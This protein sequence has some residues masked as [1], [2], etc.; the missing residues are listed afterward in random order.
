MVGAKYLCAEVGMD[1]SVYVNFKATFLRKRSFICIRFSSSI[2][3]VVLLFY[4]ITTLMP[5]FSPWELLT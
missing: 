4:E 5:G 3:Y 2:F 1:G